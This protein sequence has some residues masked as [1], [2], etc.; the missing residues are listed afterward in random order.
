MNKIN[1]II[2]A[3]NR[4][5]STDV[6]SMTSVVHSRILLGLII[7]ILTL[8]TLLFLAD[9]IAYE[10]RFVVL[11]S[12]F[13][14]ILAIEMFRRVSW[15]ELGFRKDTLVASIVVNIILIVIVGLIIVLVKQIGIIGGSADNLL[16][17]FYLFYIVISS[18]IQ[19]VLFRSIIFAEFRRSA[20]SNST[21]KVL[22]SAIIF[23]LP[24]L[25][26][27]DE[28]TLFVAAIMGVVWGWIYNRYPN[29]F[30]V[31]LSHA[32]IGSLGMIFGII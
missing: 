10:Y 20:I 32:A 1:T 19:E 21:V 6:K 29:I 17:P 12:G 9:L 28:T 3:L 31:S 16:Q 25:I 2:T 24:H 5:Y 23:T 27:L 15:R 13:A 8:I 4:Q 22:L 18:P 26:Y 11:I 30:G 14:A 7:F